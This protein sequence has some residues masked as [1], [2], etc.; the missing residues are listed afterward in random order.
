M[1]KKAWHTGITVSDLEKSITFYRDIL[2]LKLVEGPTERCYGEVISKGVGVPEADL[3]IAIFEIGSSGDRL[4]L[5]K[6]YEPKPTVDG[7]FL[8]NTPGTAHFAFHVDNVVE[9]MKK[10][11]AQGVEFL[12]DPVVGGEDSAAATAG[13]R[14]VYFK[15]P[16]GFL[17][18]LVDYQA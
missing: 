5:L 16:D 6:Y 12:S 3:A 8:A 1:I 7:P 13:W 15:D 4:E 9:T 11:K 17:L 2:G 14:W 10:L 18:E